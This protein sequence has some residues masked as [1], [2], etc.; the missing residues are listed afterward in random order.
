M[1]DAQS[2]IAAAALGLRLKAGSWKLLFSQPIQDSG[3]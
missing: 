2:M 3:V 1:R